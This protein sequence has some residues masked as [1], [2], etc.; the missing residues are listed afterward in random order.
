MKL[1][2]IHYY[3]NQPVIE[4]KDISFSTFFD[5]DTQSILQQHAN[6]QASTSLFFLDD[7]SEKKSGYYLF[8]VT[9]DT[10]IV[11]KMGLIAPPLKKTNDLF[12]EPSFSHIKL[13]TLLN[14]MEHN[15]AQFY[16]D[17]GGERYSFR[18]A[19]GLKALN[20]QSKVNAWYDEQARCNASKKIKP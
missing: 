12:D 14:N 10:S 11:K 1:Q 15:I 16:M 6:H 4:D 17:F 8:M 3:Q 2:T 9:R 5:L 20:T 7:D 18:L 13:S 19:K